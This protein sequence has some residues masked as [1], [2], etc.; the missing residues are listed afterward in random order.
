MQEITQDLDKI[1]EDARNTFG[2]LSAQQLNW[3]ASPETW[4][5]GQCFEHLIKANSAFLPEIESIIKGEKQQSFWQTYSPLSGFFGNLLFKSVSPEAPRKLKAPKRATPSASSISGTIIEEFVN[6]QAQLVQAIRQTEKL[7]AKKIVVTSPF[8]KA[9]TYSL[10]DAY[11][12]IAAHEKRH[13]QQAERV[14]H[15]A[16]FPPARDDSESERTS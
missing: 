8:I 14:M 10:F 7:D 4:S 3:K 16:G 1:G 15:A 2:R 11:R 6:H 13:F 5:V 12:I 9:I